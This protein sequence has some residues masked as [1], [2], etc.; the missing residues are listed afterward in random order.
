MKI[1]AFLLVALICSKPVYG[2]D[3]L[4][5]KYEGWHWYEQ[6]KKEEEKKTKKDMTVVEKTPTEQIK[7]TRA[8]QEKFLH[9]AIINPTEENI[10]KYLQIQKVILDNSF[11]FTSG[12]KKVM[13]THPELNETTTY[14]ISQI[15]SQ[16]YHKNKKKNQEQ[17]IKK[18][19]KTHGLFYF[20]KSGCSYCER[21][22]PIIKMFSK[23]YSF[24]LVPIALDGNNHPDLP[25]SRANIGLGEK[26]QVKAVPAVYLVEAKGKEII[27]VSFGFTGF[28]TLEDRVSFI[29]ESQQK[30]ER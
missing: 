2:F 23:K 26:L 20:Y 3:F 11:K 17:I 18:A 28:D 24:E 1:L 13:Q 19:S 16:I 25:N 29:V 30:E 15:G 6:R 7:E 4:K 8:L 12:Y 9:A 27:P 22:I 5:K 14:P 21:F 10:I